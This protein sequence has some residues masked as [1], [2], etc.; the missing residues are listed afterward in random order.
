MKEN[1]KGKVIYCRG[2]DSKF[3]KIEYIMNLFLNFGNIEII[4][5]IRQKKA[6]LIEFENIVFAT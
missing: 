3:I 2:L 6:S 4:C 1:K 5:Y